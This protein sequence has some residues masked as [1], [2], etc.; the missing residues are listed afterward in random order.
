M[1]AEKRVPS[2]DT[3]SSTRDSGVHPPLPCS[4]SILPL[5]VKFPTVSETGPDECL[6]LCAQLASY[7]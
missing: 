5:P 3:G 2:S 1:F 6:Q 7:V 4:P